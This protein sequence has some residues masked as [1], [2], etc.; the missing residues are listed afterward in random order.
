MYGGR[1][2]IIFVWKWKV[3]RSVE[4]VKATN[5]L[6]ATLSF[7]ELIHILKMECGAVTLPS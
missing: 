3:V 7:L 5:N 1:E 6:A 2:L 4:Q